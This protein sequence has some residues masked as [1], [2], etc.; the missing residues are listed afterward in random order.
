MRSSRFHFFVKVTRIQRC[1]NS[2]LVAALRREVTRLREQ[3][4]TRDNLISTLRGN[5]YQ[6]T[7]MTPEIFAQRLD[8][9]DRYI[10]FPPGTCLAFGEVTFSSNFCELIGR[11]TTLIGNF[12]VRDSSRVSARG[13]RFVSSSLHAPCFHV[14]GENTCLQLDGCALS[15]GRDGI[16]LSAGASCHLSG[17]CVA[18]NVRGGFEG[19]NCNLSALN[20]TFQNNVFHLVLLSKPGDTSR[21]REVYGC[22]NC[23]LG[24][25][26]QSRA[27]IALRYNPVTDYYD[28]LY[29]NGHAVVLTPQESTTNLVG[30]SW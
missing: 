13:I 14:S 28:C 30:P 1:E 29:R 15:S 26:P 7:S 3:I 2:E 6:A 25:P 24:D 22:E 20:C 23:F 16:F 12:Q 17:C 10:E 5:I 9:R 19:F 21:I 18:E 27:D 11:E 8:R 4:A